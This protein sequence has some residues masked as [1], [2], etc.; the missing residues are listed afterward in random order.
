MYIMAESDVLLYMK[1]NIS[2]RGVD[3]LTD[4]TISQLRQKLGPAPDSN[5]NS[6]KTVRF[7]Y[8]D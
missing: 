3:Q 2:T 5:N 4:A 6:L 1:Y 7:H 8:Y